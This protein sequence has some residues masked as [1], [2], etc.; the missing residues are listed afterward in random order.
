MSA[1]WKRKL[2]RLLNYLRDISRDYPGLSF[3]KQ[4]TIAADFGIKRPD[5]SAYGL[6]NL[7]Q[8]ASLRCR[9]PSVATTCSRR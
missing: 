4:R 6:K 1:S 3:R 9:R 8:W 5:I 2:I 7:R